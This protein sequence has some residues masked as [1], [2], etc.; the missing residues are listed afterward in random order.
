MQI[1]IS[2]HEQDFSVVFI[3]KVKVTCKSKVCSLFFLSLV[4][5]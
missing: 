2:Y 5:I 1:S 3:E 4:V